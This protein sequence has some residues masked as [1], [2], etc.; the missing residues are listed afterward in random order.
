MARG[1]FD[2][3]LNVFES[4]I[5]CATPALA[6]TS[7]LTLIQ[8]GPAMRDHG[9]R[10]GDALRSQ[11]GKGWVSPNEAR[12]KRGEGEPRVGGTRFAEDL[13]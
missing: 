4:W 3:V 11:D 10:R 12:S 5:I 8:P 7:A 6:A 9:R 1:P 13:S 2:P